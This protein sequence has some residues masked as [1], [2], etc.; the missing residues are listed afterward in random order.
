MGDPVLLAE[1]EEFISFNELDDRAATLLRTMELSKVEAVLSMGPLEDNENNSK[2]LLARMKR[3]NDARV[4]TLR[5]TDTSVKGKGADGKKG[6]K[7]EAMTRTTP[8]W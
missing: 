1:V 7:G 8:A 2:A 5:A 6:A 4:S 3:M